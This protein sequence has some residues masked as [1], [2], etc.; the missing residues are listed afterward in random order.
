MAMSYK[1]SSGL[2]S[3]DNLVLPKATGKG[4]QVDPSTPTF[5]WRDIIGHSNIRS[6]GAGRPIL[7]QYCG[8]QIYQTAYSQGDSLD[9][10]YH[11]PHDYVA[12]TDIYVHIHWSHNGTNI[13]GNA[14]FDFYTS[15][16]KGHN[17]ANFSPPG[18]KNIS[19]TYNTVDIASTPKYRHRIDE[20]V[21]SSNGGSGTLIDNSLIEPDGVL[22]IN[23]KLTTIPSITSGDLF[24]HF[25]D[26]HYQ[27]TNIGTKNK[28]PNFYS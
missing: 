8:G 27:S 1:Q 2:V 13:S 18:E 4:I 28:A 23:T 17:Q 7:K 16:S 19:I 9:F 21:I 11:I 26:I 24:V 20:V 12:G 10:E 6:T 3:T 15:Y 5:G 22:L 25:V 14:V